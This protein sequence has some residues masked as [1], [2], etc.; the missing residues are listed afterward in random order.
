[1][2]QNHAKLYFISLLLV[3][4]LRENYIRSSHIPTF[5]QLTVPGLM[6]KEIRIFRPANKLQI[7]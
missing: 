5:L 3:W 4:S 1:M 2:T 6:T 7:I